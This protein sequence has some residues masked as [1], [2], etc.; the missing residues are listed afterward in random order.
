[1]GGFAI[2]MDDKRIDYAASALFLV[3]ALS[4]IRVTLAASDPY[5]AMAALCFVPLGVVA[6]YGFAVRPPAVCWTNT[7]E[8]VIP[9]ASCCFPMLIGLSWSIADSGTSFPMI[10]IVM[11]LPGFLFALLSMFYLR[12]SFAVLPAI[13]G[14]ATKGPYKIVRHP[15]YLGETVLLIGCIGLSPNLVSIGIC[16]VSILLVIPRVGIEEK[17][18]AAD[19]NWRRYSESTRYRLIPFVF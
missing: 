17:K 6:A 16:I 2:V 15:V 19:A 18:L 1:M 7:N 12:R 11:G 10:F 14:I 13:R 3:L 8:I 4:N 5:K 9:M